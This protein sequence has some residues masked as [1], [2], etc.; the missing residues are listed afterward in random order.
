MIVLQFQDIKT[1]LGL[2]KPLEA[3]YTDI[4]LIE[5]YAVSAI[6][7]YI[8]RTIAYGT[9]TEEFDYS[10]SDIPLKA[11]PVVSITG[12]TSLEITWQLN[13]NYLVTFYGV[14]LSQKE[15]PGNK[16]TVTYTGG[17]NAPPR[18]LY[19][20]VLLQTAFEWQSRDHIGASNVTNEGGSIQRPEIGL[21]T[22]AKRLATNY[23]HPLKGIF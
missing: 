16:V 4:T 6:E 5:K 22:E 19:R 17:Y 12:I 11:L 3:D 15:K 7:N 20:A 14:Y 10:I 13:V 21:L 18:D 9:Y 8:G 2:S 23:I 1:L